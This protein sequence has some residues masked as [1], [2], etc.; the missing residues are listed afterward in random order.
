VL[1]ALITVMVLT[2][3]LRIIKHPEQQEQEQEIIKV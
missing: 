1:L 2:Q 3:F